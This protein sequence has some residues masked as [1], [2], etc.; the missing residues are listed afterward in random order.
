MYIGQA[1][2]HS[3]LFY[4]GRNELETGQKW[5]GNKGGMADFLDARHLLTHVTSRT[6]DRDFVTLY[7][8]HPRG[9]PM[10]YVAFAQPRPPARRLAQPLLPNSTASSPHTTIF[11]STLNPPK[12][13]YVPIMRLQR[14]PVD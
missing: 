5:L 2:N 8:W 4:E 9:C 10:R 11:H 3:S 12:L 7:S 1:V 13:T 14:Y 6:V